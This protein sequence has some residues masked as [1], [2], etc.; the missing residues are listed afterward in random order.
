MGVPNSGSSFGMLSL[1]R[2]TL[3]AVGS[4]DDDGSAK[5]IRRRSLNKRIHL[6]KNY[7]SI[8]LP[9]DC[10]SFDDVGVASKTQNDHAELRLMIIITFFVIT[11]IFIIT[12][13]RWP[14]RWRTRWFSCNKN[15]LWWFNR[16]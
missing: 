8:K 12:Q 4:D 5:R 15:P 1:H 13:N 9:F 11:N 3:G 7:F 16:T 14:T 10:D 6:K 2:L